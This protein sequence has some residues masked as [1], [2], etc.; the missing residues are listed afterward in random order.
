ITS[1]IVILSLYTVFIII[2][3][4]LMITFAR[5][6]PSSLKTGRY[7]DEQQ[8]ASLEDKLAYQTQH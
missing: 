3:G 5:K 7:H 8:P 4:Y 2:E 6:G 1:L